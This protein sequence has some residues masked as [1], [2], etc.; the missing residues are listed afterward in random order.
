M[1][2]VPRIVVRTTPKLYRCI[3]VPYVQ[4]RSI[5]S[6]DIF[7]TTKVSCFLLQHIYLFFKDVASSIPAAPLPPLPGKTLEELVEV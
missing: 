1:L 7:N 3:A 5:S 6:A 4:Q 2:S